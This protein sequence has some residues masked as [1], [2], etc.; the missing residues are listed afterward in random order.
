MFV[1]TALGRKGTSAAKKKLKAL[2]ESSSVNVNVRI[3]ALS[4]IAHHWKDS[5][6][7]SYLEKQ[8][9][10]DSKLSSQLTTLKK[11]VYKK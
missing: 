5:S 9:K 4:A 8:A 7:I 10:S 2:L 1:T 3:G 6:D 11:K